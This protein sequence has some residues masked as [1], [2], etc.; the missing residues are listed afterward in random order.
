MK[1]EIPNCENQTEDYLC[2]T[3]RLQAQDRNYQVTGCKS[4][5]MIIKIETKKDIK[6]HSIIFVDNCEYCPFF[7]KGKN[8]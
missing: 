5:G 1:C 7:N 4:C 6:E 8:K 2:K 3:H